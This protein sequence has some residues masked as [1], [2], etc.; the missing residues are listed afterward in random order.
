MERW[1]WGEWKGREESVRNLEGRLVHFE[2]MLGN[3]M[4]TGF[5]RESKKKKDGPVG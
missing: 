3:I 2:I 1:D 5:A 4:I